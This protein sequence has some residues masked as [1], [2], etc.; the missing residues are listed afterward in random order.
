LTL[1]DA[2]AGGASV[3]GGT[4]FGSTGV[5]TVEGGVGDTIVGG[6]GAN[7]IDA[8]AGTQII[9]GSLG[10]STVIAGRGDY[11]DGGGGAL[12]IV[13]PK[14]GG[15][16]SFSGGIGN[17]TVF[18]IGRSDTIV[19]GTGVPGGKGV[20]TFVNDTYTGTVLGGFSLI[21]GGND[22]V[23]GAANPAGGATVGAN[24]WV[25]GQVGD[26][27]IGGRGTMYVDASSGSESV[28]GGSATANVTI[29]SLQTASGGTAIQGGNLDT[30]TGGSGTLQLYINSNVGAETVNLGAG[31]GAAALRDVD[32]G[33]GGASTSVSGFSTAIDVV[34]SRTSIDSLGVFLGMSQ[35]NGSGGTILMFIDGSTMTLAGVA[36]IA[37]IKFTQ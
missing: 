28:I 18:D 7:Y 34:Q 1:I 22:T 9:H 16:G 23:T 26:T 27:V 3:D 6:F 10:E 19:G 25:I 14:A 5:S 17:L 31:H 30:I 8:S 12:V 33:A 21:T 13:D 37:A 24:T 36:S 32:D 20:T 11:I 35:S 15:F 4:A 2:T 29:P